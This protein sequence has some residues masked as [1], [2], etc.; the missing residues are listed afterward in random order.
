MFLFCYIFKNIIDIIILYDV[1]LVLAYILY[2]KN[3][4]VTTRTLQQWAMAAAFP[5]L[6]NDFRFEASI[7]WLTV[8]KQKHKIKQRKITKYVSKREVTTLEQ[9]LKAAEQFQKQTKFL[10]RKFDLD[11]VINTDQTGCQ[12]QMSYNRSLD[13]QGVKSV[14][15]KKQN[16]NKLTHSYTTQYCITASGKLVPQ[17][18]LCLQEPT[19]KFGPQVLTVIDKLELEFKNIVV[20]CSKSGKLTKDLYG[21]FL[22]SILVPYVKQNKFLL[23]ID[24]WGGKQI[25]IC[26]IVFLKTTL[27]KQLAH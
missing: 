3:L 14:L 6:S 15:V 9:T 16:L 11:L 12:Y 5:F 1:I 23:I 2:E 18:F 22:E 26:T 7:S 20:T 19:G 13:F 25:A 4:Q 24:S 10:I 17:V 8:F 21:Q 27:G